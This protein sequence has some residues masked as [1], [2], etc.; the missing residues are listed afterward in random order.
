MKTIFKTIFILSTL[1]FMCSCVEEYTTHSS[2]HGMIIDSFDNTPIEGALI[3]NQ[4]TGKNCLT[5][6][7]GQYEFHNLEFNKTYKIYV[8]KDGYIPSSQS[9]TPSAIRD[10][11][12][13]N[14]KLTRRP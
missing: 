12:E 10:N 5:Q 14:I 9:I 11:I 7:D 3:T 1:F 2:I 8:E 4:A 6:A 13:L